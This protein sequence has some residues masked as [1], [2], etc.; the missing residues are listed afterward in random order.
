MLTGKTSVSVQR[1][2]HV[3]P[4]WVLDKLLFHLS[5]PAAL[6]PGT[7]FG[8][9]VPLTQIPLYPGLGWERGGFPPSSWSSAV[10]WILHEN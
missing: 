10:F 8:L 6:Q 2:C 4:C 7:S 5:Q 3:E 9:A 1:I